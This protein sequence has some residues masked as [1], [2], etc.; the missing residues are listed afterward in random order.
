[1]AVGTG[2]A[3]PQWVRTALPSLPR[4]MAEADQRAHAAERA[5]I[6]IAEALVLQHRV[7][8]V[9]RGVVVEAAAQRG[10]IQL[11]EPAVRGRL[12]GDDL[13]LGAVVNARLTTCDVASRLVEFT[14]VV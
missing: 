14:A 7:G 8:E 1:V 2:G 9:F 4:L 6:G 11:T 3:V 12:V 5:V 13:K 10:E